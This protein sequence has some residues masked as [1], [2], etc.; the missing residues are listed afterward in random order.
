VKIKVTQRAN[1]RYTTAADGSRVKAPMPTCDY[2]DKPIEVE[3]PYR[4]TSRFRG[5]KITRHLSC[6]MWHEWEI[7]DSVFAR[8]LKIGFDAD[9]EINSLS[10]GSEDDDVQTVLGSIAEQIRELATEREEAVSNIEDGFGHET[11]QSAEIQEQADSLNGWA[12]DVESLS[13]DERPVE[14]EEDGKAVTEDELNDWI[15]TI[16]DAIRDLVN[17]VPI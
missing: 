10:S 8:A 17:E 1:Q 16:K 11:S 5:P 6:P 12:D 9:D 3:T 7:S 2:C 15:D 13:V 14:E 4:Y